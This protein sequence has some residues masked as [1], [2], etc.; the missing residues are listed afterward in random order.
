MTLSLRFAGWWGPLPRP[1]AFGLVRWLMRGTVIEADW[2]HCFTML[3]GREVVDDLA[4][5][6]ADPDPVRRIDMGLRLVW[7]YAGCSN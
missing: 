3:V 2:T 7:S 5:R 4:A 1:V 6:T